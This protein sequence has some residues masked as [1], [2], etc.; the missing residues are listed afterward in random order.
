MVRRLLAAMASL[1][2]VVTMEGP[3]RADADPPKGSRRSHHK[4]VRITKDLAHGSGTRS[5]RP[6]FSRCDW[7]RHVITGWNAL[8]WRLW[9]YTHR[10]IWC[11]NEDA[12]RVTRFEPLRRG[13]TAAW[14]P[15]AFRGVQS[16][17][18]Y[19]ATDRR[20]RA[21]MGGEFTQGAFDVC[22]FDFCQHAEPSSW[23]KVYPGYRFEHGY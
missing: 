22:A 2:M 9:A 7:V 14:T 19:A 6:P 12:T 4:M 21:R 5:S 13:W 1:A 16:V 23:F 11:W 18:P 20:G 15:W 3:V 8:D 10:I 17:I